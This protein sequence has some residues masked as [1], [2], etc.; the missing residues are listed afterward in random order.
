M[1]QMNLD[2]KMRLTLLLVG[3]MVV[4]TIILLYSQSIRGVSYWDIFVYLENAM[5]FSGHNIGSQLALPPV[6]SLLVAIPFNL[7]FVNLM[8]MYIVAGILFILLAVGI[9]E[10]FCEKFTPE[11]S[12]VSS[13]IFSMLTLV[14][15]WA[16]TGATD[17]PSLTFSVW[18]VVFTIYGLNRNFNYYYL[19]FG[20]FMLS[21]FTRYT[22]GFIL[23]VMGVYLLMNLDKVYKQVMDNKR[24][25]AQL[26]AFIVILGIIISAIYLLNQGSIPFISQFVEVS[27]S[28]QVSSVNIGYELNPFYYLENLPELLTSTSVT[29]SYEIYLTI[30]DNSPTILSYVILVLSAVGILGFFKDVLKR[31]D[32]SE[33][34]RKYYPLYLVLI[35]VLSIITIFTYNDVSY[36]VTE[37][38][39][40]VLLLFAYSYNKENIDQMDL[41]MFLWIG[42]YLIL[43]SY[44][45]VKVDR[46]IIPIFIPIIYYMSQAVINIVKTIPERYKNRN[47]KISKNSA[48]IIISI[49]LLLLIPINALYL[50]SITHPNAHSTEEESSATWLSSYDPDLH[51]KI[52]SSDRGVAYSWYLDK[53]TYSTI[54]RVLNSENQTLEENLEKI[55][56]TYYIDSTSKINSING[57]HVI[58]DNNNTENPVKIYERN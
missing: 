34:S 22:S 53:Y 57:F 40:I 55:N 25:L 46:Y 39:F 12:L 33:N 21:F 19:A 38:L 32:N 43:H 49:I 10:L 8:S 5:L 45:P 17:L 15:T 41:L 7:G 35:V 1:F 52:L 14:V 42:I 9:Y 6:F 29:S 36:L 28:S 4:Y 47:P 26:V 58:Y 13:I 37:I 48:L 11:I 30:V 24:K 27:S 31:S 51:D 18:A 20:F 3:I 2:K 56:A 50:D 44:H 16:L 23:L 54:P